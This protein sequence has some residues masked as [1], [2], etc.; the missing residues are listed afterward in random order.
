MG[1]DNLHHKKRAGRLKRERR[2]I[3]EYKN[4]IL[5]ICEGEKTE[6]EY[7]EKFPIT[8]INVVTIGIGKSNIALIEDAIVVW[9]KNADEGK[10][11]ERLWCVFDRDDFPLRNYN[12]AFKS[13]LS[14]ETRLNKKF[15]KK[16]GRNVNINI[17]YSNQAFE[18]WYLL[19]FDYINTAL[20]RS[21]YQEMLS[22]R[23]NR[24]YKKNDPNMYSLLSKSQ[25][26]A[27]KNAKKLKASINMAL[28]HNHN[29]STTVYKLVEELNTYLKK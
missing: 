22:Q 8:N 13:I 29:P 12:Q 24:R 17:A 6:P 10:Y 7:F 27:I 16:T 9:K 26:F 4:S 14:E 20:D 21:Q 28:K 23:M 18:L 2:K 25:D 3:R 1:S 5:I 11:F 19:H 15:R